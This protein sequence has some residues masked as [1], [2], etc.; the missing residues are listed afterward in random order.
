MRRDKSIKDSKFNLVDLEINSIWLEID[1]LIG[2][3]PTHGLIDLVFNSTN[4]EGSFYESFQ[5][6]NCMVKIEIAELL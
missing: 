4:S 5:T 3:V 2:F 1:N 6:F